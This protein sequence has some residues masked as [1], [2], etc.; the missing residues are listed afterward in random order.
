MVLFSPFVGFVIGLLFLILLA[1]IS[2]LSLFSGHNT[3]RTLTS[4]YSC[5]FNLPLPPKVE[6]VMYSPFLPVLPVCVQDLKKLWT[7][8]DEILWTDLVC[9]KDELIRFW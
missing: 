2:I 7:D 1:L 6:V 9:D 5:F 4:F 3:S 8:P